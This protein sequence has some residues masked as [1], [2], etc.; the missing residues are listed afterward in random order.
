MTN[1]RLK[2]VI[3]LVY[4]PPNIDSI[5][6]LCNTV[7]LLAKSGYGVD[8]IT[9]SDYT[10][11]LPKFQEKNIQIVTIHRDF[12]VEKF[13]QFQT[14]LNVQNKRVNSFITLIR[15]GVFL[16]NLIIKEIKIALIPISL[17]LRH[18]KNTYH[19]FIGVDPE[20]LIIASHCTRFIK[21]PVIYYSLELLLSQ[22]VVRPS[23]RILKQKEVAFS[24]RANFIII[25]DKE[26]ALLMSKDNDIPLSQFVFVPNSPLGTSKRKKTNYWYKRFNISREIKIVIHSGSIGSWTGKEQIIKSVENW[27]ENWVLIIHTKYSSEQN[28]E[29]LKLQ[30]NSNPEKVFFSLKP[31]SWQ[32]YDEMI[33]S[34]DIG[35]AFYVI[36]SGSTYLQE[37]IR[38]VGL[39]SGKIAYYLKSG[40]PVITNKESS[41]SDLILNAKCGISVGS[42]KDIGGAIVSI[43]ENYDE[44][45]RN[46]QKFFD[47]NLNFEKKFLEVI[48]RIDGLEN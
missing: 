23:D 22:E 14:K 3:A 4:L 33:D 16:I 21:V 41:T 36:I 17:Y 8:I 24:K 6:S 37:N 40:L 2:K 31:V 26:R 35:I 20:G 39:S 38:S 7:T 48:Y 12:V 42:C 5:P 18:K 9:T 13:V 45:S 19:C 15:K 47:L 28:E 1:I 30:K 44:Y 29:I 11:V 32:E 27:P 34:A 25:Q 43:S 10:C 46:A